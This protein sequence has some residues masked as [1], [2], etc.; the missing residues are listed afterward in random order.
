MHL[1]VIFWEWLFFLLG[2]LCQL[3]QQDNF[4]QDWDNGCALLFI[5][6]TALQVPQLW[7]SGM[8]WNGRT[9]CSEAQP[10]FRKHITSSSSCTHA[11][12]RTQ[13][14]SPGSLINMVWLRK[15]FVASVS[16]CSPGQ[17]KTPV[18]QQNRNWVL[19]AWS[20][21]ACQADLLWKAVLWSWSNKWSRKSD[22]YRL[23]K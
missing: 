9:G 22:F 23:L 19:S 16:G 3:G 6:E 8:M 5:I 17:V 18:I 21:C 13:S 10:T 12:M 11:W 4:L 2:A 1:Q 15:R 14:C 20:P 7:K